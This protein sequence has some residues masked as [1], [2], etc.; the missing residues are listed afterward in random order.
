MSNNKFTNSRFD[1]LSVN[2]VDLGQS[3][4][5]FSYYIIPGLLQWFTII[6][7]LFQYRRSR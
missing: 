7:Y 4:S 6:V 3:D 2:G 1:T 5:G